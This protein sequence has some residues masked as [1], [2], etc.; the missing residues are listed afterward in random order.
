[1]TE[2]ND[3]TDWSESSRFFIA[4]KALYTADSF[5]WTKMECRW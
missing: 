5:S 4:L 1:M 2:K 3:D